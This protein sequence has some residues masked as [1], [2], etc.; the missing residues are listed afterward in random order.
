M[1]ILMYINSKYCPFKEFQNFCNAKL[2]H[3]EEA[4]S[5]SGEV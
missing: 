1:C 5:E 4:L 2:N 3:R